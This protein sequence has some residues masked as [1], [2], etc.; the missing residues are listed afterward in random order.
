MAVDG[1]AGIVNTAPSFEARPA[2]VRR[3]HN[4][5]SSDLA[6]LITGMDYEKERERN[7]VIK[8]EITQE[9]STLEKEEENKPKED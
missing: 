9:E 3:A 7:I 1:N 4:L 5:A 2:M 6:P 8:R